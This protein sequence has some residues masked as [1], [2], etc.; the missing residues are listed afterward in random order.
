MHNPIKRTNAA[1]QPLVQHPAQLIVGTHVHTL[2]TVMQLLKQKW[3]IRL[4]A[5]N[6]CTA[7]IQIENRQH[8][9][10]TWVTPNTD[11]Y[12]RNDLEVIFRTLSF[13]LET[14]ARHILVIEHADMLTSSCANS[15][16]KSIEEPPHGYQ[17]ILLAA[18]A[19]RV[20]PTIRSR[21]IIHFVHAPDD[22]QHNHP[23]V[24]LLCSNQ[25]PASVALLAT[26][27]KN[28]LSEQE[29]VVLIEQAITHWKQTLRVAL[30]NHDLRTQQHARARINFLC[31]TLEYPP[32]PGSSKL[33][34]R[35][36]F[37]RWTLH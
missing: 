20:L 28:D 35:N 4:N 32:M 14:H 10:V 19:E 5:C 31:R 1:T 36:V 18:C 6:T 13:S 25:V 15:L 33:F 3:C 22:V 34:W 29:S 26:L 30:K 8:E 17:F 11:A 27:E 9:A 37:L 12:T 21:C 2:K 24:T 16:L 23:L 7:C